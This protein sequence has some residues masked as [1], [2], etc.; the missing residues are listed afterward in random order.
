VSDPIFWP[1]VRRDKRATHTNVELEQLVVAQAYRRKGVATLLVN[2]GKEKADELGI[3]S[4]VESTP[5]AAPIYERLGYGNVDSLDPD[6]A[7]ESPSVRYQEYAAEDLRVFLMWRPTGH[8]YDAS[9]DK[10]SWQKH[11]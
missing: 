2:W 7:V 1:Y 4:C 9:K 3:E 8:D 5:F 10:A 6:V 11:I